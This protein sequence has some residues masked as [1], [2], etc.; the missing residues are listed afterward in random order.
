MDYPVPKF[1]DCT[2]VLSAVLVLL[3]RQTHK[4]AES[5]T[6]VANLYTTVGVDYRRRV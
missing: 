3:C 5:H 4:R 2:V 6:D 1:G